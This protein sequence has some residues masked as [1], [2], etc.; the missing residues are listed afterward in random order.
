[1]IPERFDTVEITGG[2]RLEGTVSTPGDKSISHRALLIGAL[3]EG[4]S[5]I[6]GLSNGDDVR[7]TAS[8]LRSLGASV[9]GDDVSLVVD[10]GRGR[11]HEAGPIDLG[12]SGT[13]MRLLAGLAAGLPWTT[14]LSGDASLT[15]RPM[16][17]I[18]EPLAAMGANLVGRGPTQLPPLVIEGGQLHGIDWTPPMASAQVKSAILFAGLAATGVTVVREAIPTRAHTEEM[19]AAAG[20]A[21][22]VEP[23]ETGRLVRIKAS[24]LHPIDLDIPGDPSQAA[25]WIVAA[26]VIPG[27]RIVVE[28]VYSG[29]E[30]IGFMKVLE[31]MGASVLVTNEVGE[32][33]DLSASYST[34]H[35]T[36]ID[37]AEI[38]SLDEIPILA[39]AAAGAHGTTTFR[40]VRELTVKETDRLVASIALVEAVGARAWATGDDLAIEGTGMLGPRPVEFHSRGDHRLAM[41]AIVA[42]LADPAGGTIGGVTSVDTSYPGFLAQVDALAG[43]GAWGPGALGEADTDLG[44]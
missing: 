34:L 35:G 10:G 32:T 17:R 20:A 26:C 2:R 37:A 19:L 13:S 33:A 16:D 28:H 31:R 40:D 15:G 27:S 4:T 43:P 5:T 21:I 41:A 6:R 12:N 36:E 14:T 30:R 39:V 29:V 25:F 38:P 7:R 3:A 8:A 44:Q 18:A 11:M 22:E 24:A 1:V 9:E 42:A 23:W